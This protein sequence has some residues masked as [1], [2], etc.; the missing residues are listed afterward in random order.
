[1]AAMEGTRPPIIL[2][3]DKV[4]LGF[5]KSM[6]GIHLRSPSVGLSFL[7]TIGG[8]AGMAAIAVENLLS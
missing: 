8:R 5:S 3:K 4:T 1:M 7:R 2:T 6:A